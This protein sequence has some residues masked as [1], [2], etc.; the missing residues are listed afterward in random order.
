MSVFGAL[1]D[2]PALVEA[3]LGAGPVG[4]LGVP[5][6]RA[7]REGR[8]GSENRGPFYFLFSRVNGVFLDLAC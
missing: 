8:Q 6:V 1:D 4:K 2:L 7:D 3:A 5:A